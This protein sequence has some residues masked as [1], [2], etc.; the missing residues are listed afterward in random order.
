MNEFDQKIGR[1]LRELRLAHGY[2]QT[3]IGD[4]LG[5]TFQQV[6]KI[7]KGFN[8][9]SART[10]YLLKK[11]YKIE[12]EEFFDTIDA[13]LPAASIPYRP[14]RVLYNVLDEV[15]PIEVQKSI[16]QLIRA[17]SKSAKKGGGTL[18]KLCSNY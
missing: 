7:E 5:V 1:K 2:N 12:W 13:P 16:Y 15:E 6:Q 18:K 8:R 14:R 4:L 11:Q 10:L 9:T 3:A 17:I